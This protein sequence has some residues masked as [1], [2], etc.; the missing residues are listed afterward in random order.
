V[1]EVSDFDYPRSGSKKKKKKMA[2]R[3]QNMMIQQLE[4]VVGK[5]GTQ[6][7]YLGTLTENLSVVGTIGTFNGEPA[8]FRT[9]I[10]AV[11][12]YVLLAGT[13]R[14]SAIRI[15]FQTSQGLVSD[16]I[17]RQLGD[18]LTWDELKRQLT[19]RFGEVT[20][21]H[22]A[23]ALLQKCRQRKE[24]S[25]PLYSER[26][27]ELANDAYPDGLGGPVQRQLV[28]FF[29][30]GLADDG[31][32]LKVLREE[33][34]CIEE[35]I[36]TAHREASL[37]KRFSLRLNQGPS[38]DTPR[39]T[40]NHESRKV[41]PMEIGHMRAK[42]CFKCGKQGHRAKDC[43]TVLAVSRRDKA[44]VCWRCGQP[45]HLRRECRVQGN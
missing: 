21:R 17:Q 15:A 11:E 23:F 24:E 28:D 44:L 30:D 45:G 20:D 22:H 38:R 43:R 41:E 19:Q 39:P 26:L 16:Y 18:H 14:N 37:R 29:I 42:G 40:L 1:V 36:N 5:M 31:L 25:V 9:W 10:K 13:A 6:N 35:A 34:L 2:E 27:L 8:K 4:E 7:Q 33:P 32:K 3:D 12:K